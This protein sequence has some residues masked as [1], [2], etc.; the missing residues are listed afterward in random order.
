MRF[1]AIASVLFTAAV[2]VIAG[3]VV[4]RDTTSSVATVLTTLKSN[5]T[6]YVNQL[7]E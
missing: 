6:P 1:F 2:G 7:S 5:V 3:P 4:E